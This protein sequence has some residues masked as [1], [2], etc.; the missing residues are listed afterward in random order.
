MIVLKQ[1][2]PVVLNLF[3]VQSKTLNLKDDR[4]LNQINENFQLVLCKVT[5]AAGFYFLKLLKHF[6]SISPAGFITALR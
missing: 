2:K 3:L 1:S 6:T 5:A 4:S